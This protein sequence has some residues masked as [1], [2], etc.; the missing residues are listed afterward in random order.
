MC[1]RVHLLCNVHQIE[2][3]ILQNLYT[4]ERRGREWVRNRGRWPRIFRRLGQCGQIIPPEV[5]PPADG[6]RFGVR[7]FGFGP[8]VTGSK[9]GLLR[10][11]QDRRRASAS[12]KPTCLCPRETGRDSP[13]PPWHPENLRAATEQCPS[14]LGERLPGSELTLRLGKDLFAQWRG[15][16]HGGVASSPRAGS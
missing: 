7:G 10:W 3:P 15:D 11:Q 16:F 13:A 1:L 5:T 6:G 2:T 9:A 12:M 8:A 4:D 14:K